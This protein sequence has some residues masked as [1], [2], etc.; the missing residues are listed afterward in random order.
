MQNKFFS[1]ILLG[2][3]LGGCASDNQLQGSQAQM[4]NLLL[5][6]PAPMSVRSQ[7]AI[8]RYSQILAKAPLEEHERAELL[9]QRGMLY[10]SVGL[11]GLAQYDFDHAIRCALH[12]ADEFYSSL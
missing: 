6:E 4:S 2:F 1:L 5:A 3:L 7:M 9:H 8:A 10:D 12:T 11:A